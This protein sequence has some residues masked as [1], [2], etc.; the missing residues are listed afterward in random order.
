MNVTATLF[1]Q[2][3]TF[4]VL[5]W[6]VTRFLWTPLTG[7]MAAR[8]KRIAD[9][10]AAAEQGRNELAAAES[11]REQ[12]L[13]ESRERAAE[14]MIQA[15]RHAVEIMDEA[16]GSARTEAE[17]ILA[18]ARDD[19]GRE[20]NRAKKE[21]GAAVASLA[22]EGAGKIIE[23]EVDPKVHEALLKRLIEQL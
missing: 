15:E 13:H 11:A 17:R 18:Q 16:R 5:V 6:F 7:L 14:L 23:R 20:F 8:A 12:M 19:I 9:G 2:L 3:I 10:L 1:G 21:L 22:V 4:A